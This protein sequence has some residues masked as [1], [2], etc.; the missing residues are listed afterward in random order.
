MTKRQRRTNDYYPTPPCAAMAMR[1]VFEAY[2]KPGVARV[3]D[4]AAGA[5]T[6]LEWVAPNDKLTA[7]ELHPTLAA[8]CEARGIETWC[9][10]ARKVPEPQL[11]ADV[12]IANPPFNLLSS[13]VARA[14]HCLRAAI[15]GGRQARAHILI[16]TAWIQASERTVIPQPD[17][18]LLTWRPAFIPRE[19]GVSGPSQVYAIATWTSETASLS[20]GTGTVRRLMKPHPTREQLAEFKRISKLAEGL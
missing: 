14:L 19:E 12:I 3:I 10:D 20:R 6:L 5:G 16:P 13:F 4:P 11:A 18:A 15:V 9:G 2:R 8:E 7:I 17:L 1:E